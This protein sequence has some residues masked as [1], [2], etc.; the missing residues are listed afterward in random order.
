MTINAEGTRL[1]VSVRKSGQSAST[2]LAHPRARC[3]VSKESVS[4]SK[5]AMP[6]AV[7]VSSGWSERGQRRA[8]EPSG[9]SVCRE[10]TRENSSLNTPGEEHDHDDG[11]QKAR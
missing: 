7:R 1:S 6:L 8:N 4:V 5:G 10:I 9:A 11:E 3:H 2:A